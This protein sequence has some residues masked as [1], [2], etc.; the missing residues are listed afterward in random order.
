M[1]LNDH[2]MPFSKNSEMESLKIIYLHSHYEKDLF[3]KKKKS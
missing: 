1:I 3:F 2:F